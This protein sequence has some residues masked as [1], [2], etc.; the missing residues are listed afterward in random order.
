ML[1]VCKPTWMV[2]SVYHITAKS[3][4]QRG[5]KAVLTDLDNTLI[6]WDD[7]TLTSRTYQWLREL[8]AHH[9]PV[10]IVSNNTKK[11][12]YGA[13]AQLKSPVVA[14]AQKPFRKGLK[15]AVHLTG[16][17]REHILLI[18][19]Q[20]LTDVIGANRIGIDVALVKPLVSSDAWMTRLNRKVEASIL[21]YLMT[22]HPEMKWRNALHD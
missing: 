8:E 10:V 15:K 2:E 17:E 19:D 13:T 9:I 1:G 16:C 12:V 18:G 6:A 7:Q 3:L 22:H 11:R 20:V 4:I 14:S 21:T 5:Y